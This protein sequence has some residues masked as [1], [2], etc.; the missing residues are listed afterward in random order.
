MIN[1]YFYEHYYDK[2]LGFFSLPIWSYLKHSFFQI[3][4]KMLFQIK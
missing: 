1:I 2:D 3:R 4:K